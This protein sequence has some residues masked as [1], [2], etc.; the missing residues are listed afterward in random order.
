MAHRSAGENPF[1][2]G[3]G[4]L[5][6]VLAGRSR[7]LALA[8]GSLDL[9]EG[10]AGPPRSLLFFGPRGNGKTTLLTRIAEEAR[11]RSLLAERLPAAV[12]ADERR[13]VRRLQ[14]R[15]GQ[16]RGRITGAQ[17]AV[18]GV[19]AEP[20]PATEDVEE[21]L[22]TWIGESPRPL[23]ILLDEAHTVPPE[24]GRLFFD[25][26]Q[27]ATA[28][29]LPFL[30]LA[31][32]TPDAPRRLRQCGTFT[33]RALERVPV[34]RLERSATLEAL[35]EPAKQSG[36][37]F[38]RDAAALLAEESQDYPYFIQLL[39]R[40]AWDAARTDAAAVNRETALRAKTATHAETDR[41]FA[42][43]YAEARGRGV[44][45]ALAPLAE[46]FSQ[47]GARVPEADLQALLAE[48]APRASIPADPAALLDTLSDLGVLWETPPSGWEL[49][50][51]S[52]ADFLLAHYRD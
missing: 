33:E 3:A 45:A 44:A 22:L 38:R 29:E 20:A 11:Q 16:L 43:R 50:I 30:L 12:V 9:L 21:L 40:A 46:L 13:L 15:T 1:R 42:E 26:L 39:G 36:L 27:E 18:L 37:P 41:F 25:A 6:P 4:A 34:G 31:A 8:R 32:G 2:P 51:P 49:G 28:R 52:F 47:R 5:P 7:E 10:G 35:T 19:S 17:A 24:A 48:I 23:V 14:E